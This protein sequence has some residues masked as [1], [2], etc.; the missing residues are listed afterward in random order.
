MRPYRYDGLQYSDA[1]RLLRL[2]PGAGDR[3]EF[4]LEH[5]RL[6]EA[7]RSYEALSYTWGRMSDRAI[8]CSRRGELRI[9]LNLHHALRRM[10]H[11]KKP[12]FIWADS[13]CIDQQNTTE[14]GHQV[15]LMRSIYRSAASVLIWLG[16]TPLRE[17]ISAF[18]VLSSIASGGRVGGRPVGQAHFLSNGVSSI[19][20]PELSQQLGPPPLESDLWEAVANLFNTSWFQRVWCIQE[21]ALAR[22]ATIIW[23]DAEMPWRWVGLAATRIRVHLYPVLARYD[24]GGIFNA[25]LMYRLSK[26]DAAVGHLVVP[27]L[28]LVAMT[29][30]FHATDPRD[31]VYGLLGL[32]TTDASPDN[33]L[34]FLDP[35]YT[36]PLE[37]VY[38]RFAVRALHSS[39][40]LKL[41]SSVQH[42][43]EIRY[44]SWVPRWGSIH[45]SILARFSGDDTSNVSSDM[46]A[47]YEIAAQGTS[48]HVKGVCVGTVSRIFRLF[49]ELNLAPE[50]FYGARSLIESNSVSEVIAREKKRFLS[51][52]CPEDEKESGDPNTL[53][54][55]LLQNAETQARLCHTMTGNRNWQGEVA[56]DSEQHLSDFFA[57]LHEWLGGTEAARLIP[58]SQSNGDSARFREAVRNVMKG[59]RLFAIGPDTQIGLGPNLLQPD[60][61]VCVV[62]GCPMPLCLRPEHGAFSLVGE[63]YFQ[64]FMQGEAVELWRA[65]KLKDQIFEIR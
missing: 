40:S 58:K 4:E 50:L 29:C 7:P 47:S 13:A 51:L 6:S 44:P 19:R 46:C 27:F 21:V 62:F 49:P 37:E 48:L 15:R 33:G 39:N 63:C 10:R 34:F 20:I 31:R 59:R 28:E 57:F 54:F 3:I 56:H 38:R 64:E 65:G 32:P 25:Y 23:G 5:A 60:D 22:H 53:L 17:A 12:R 18:A 9:P 1:I 52:F 26:G 24:M 36:L 45:T 41:L 55:G 61:Q 30:Q 11:A 16:W 43:S 42:D 14:R 8:I 2:E 35:D